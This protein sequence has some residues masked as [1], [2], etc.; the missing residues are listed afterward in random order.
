M[1]CELSGCH[2][3]AVEQVLVCGVE[4]HVCE[5]H[6]MAVKDLEQNS[7]DVEPGSLLE[8]F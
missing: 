1:E 3:T 5:F 6:A 8:P 2:A 7:A 4:R